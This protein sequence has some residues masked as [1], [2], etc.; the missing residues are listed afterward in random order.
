MEIIDTL[1]ATKVNTP[2]FAVNL[3]AANKRVSVVNGAS[4][5]FMMNNSLKYYFQ[6]GDN[7]LLLNAGYFIPESF[8]TTED[9]APSDPVFPFL[10]FTV[11]DSAGVSKGALPGLGDY[12][13]IIV[14]FENYEGTYN[15]F[16]DVNSLYNT[17][18]YKLSVV[19]TFNY[20]M[21]SMINVPS[22]LDGK[23]FYIYPFIKV[24][25]TLPMVA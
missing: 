18:K 23:T 13:G 9:M 6:A 14:P 1:I 19:M 2:Y 25:H 5:C 17:G 12:G 10:L 7:L 8:C 4:P 22:D 21:I 3:A 20:T 11:F 16:C 15:V 24:L